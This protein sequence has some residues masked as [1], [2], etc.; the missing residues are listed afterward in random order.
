[1]RTIAWI[2]LFLFADFVLGVVIGKCIA[3]GAGKDVKPLL[4]WPR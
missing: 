2:V 1:M 4:R 3:L